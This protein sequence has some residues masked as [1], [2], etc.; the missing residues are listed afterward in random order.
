MVAYGIGVRINKVDLYKLKSLLKDLETFSKVKSENMLDFMQW[1]K[2]EKQN[3]MRTKILERLLSGGDKKIYV[4]FGGNRSGKTE[5]GAGIVAEYIEKKDNSQIMCATVDYKLSV[6]VQQSKISKLVRVSAMEYGKYSP[7]RG[8][9]NETILMKNGAKVLFRTYQQGRESIQGMDLDLVWL[10]E[11]CPWDFYQEALAR[12]ADRNGVILFTFTSLSGFTRLVNF[13]WDSNNELIET[14]VLSIIDNPFI[15][16]Q[17][18]KYYMETI[19]PDEIESRIHGRPHIKEGLIYKEFSK[20]NKVKR[21]DYY[22]MVRKDPSTWE[23][24]EGIDPHERT[25]HHWLRFLYNKKKD[26]IYVVE[27][28]KAPRE[29]MIIK[30]FVRIL[31]A[32]RAGQVPK[33]CQIDTS[34]MKP[35]VIYK[36]PDEDQENSH[37]IRL[38][39]FECGIETILCVKDNAMGIG[40]V[41]ERLKVVKNSLGDIKRAPMLYIFDDLDGVLWEISRYSWGSFATATASEKN[42]MINKPLKKDDHFMDILKYECIKLKTDL[43]DNVQMQEYVDMYGDMGY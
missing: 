32:K 23:L 40:C 24:H 19:D 27:E 33:F 12:T 17:A 3:N 22:D 13:L 6:A 39:F 26:I 16:E 28:L 38:E 41:K 37:T 34:S 7:V 30:D 15:P 21:F 20:V 9:S 4:V 18:K 1:D 25:P 31:K 14:E 5:L 29:S 43:E 2:Y 35:D 36:H 10:D 8:Y 11:E 42:E